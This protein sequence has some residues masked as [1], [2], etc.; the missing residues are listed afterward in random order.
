MDWSELR[1]L[2][3][4]F[5]MLIIPGW[6]ILAATNLWRKFDVIERWIFAVG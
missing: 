4:I 2:F 1:I 6:A 3:I 5:L